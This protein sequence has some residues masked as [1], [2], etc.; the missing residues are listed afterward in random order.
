M[1]CPEDSTPQHSTLPL[2]LPFLPLP[3]LHGSL[4]LG[5]G[6]V[7][8]PFITE[9]SASILITLSHSGTL[10]LPLPAVYKSSV[11]KVE[12]STVLWA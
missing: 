5:E 7:A 11:A 10:L 9:Q 6:G 2:A 8:V 1:R 12:S 4:S 3:L